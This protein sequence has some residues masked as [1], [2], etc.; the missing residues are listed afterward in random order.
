MARQRKVAFT[1]DAA[2]RVAKA[3]LAFERGNRDQSPITFRQVSDDGD[4]IRI[5][6][7]TAQWNKGTLATITLYEGGTPPSETA[8]DP[9]E[10]IEDAVNKFADVPMNKWVALAK[11]ANGSWYMI[12]AEC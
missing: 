6:K 10:T 7:T 9:A 2:A 5:G 8:N 11:A 1:E 4:P 3:T 12:A